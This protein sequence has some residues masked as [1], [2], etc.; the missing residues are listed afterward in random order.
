[1]KQGDFIEIDF[2]GRILLTGEIF[3]L[4]LES[5]AK[6][7]NIYNKNHKYKPKLVVV[8]NGMVI[9]GVERE[10]EKMKVG[11]E[12][13]FEVKP[14]DALGNR[15]QK[16]I[17]ILSL[18]KFKKENINPAPGIFVDI[19]GIT[20][21]IQS[22]SGGRVMVDFNHP[23]A[24]KALKYWIRINKIIEEPLEKAKAMLDHYGIKCET[25]LEGETLSIKLD[26]KTDNIVKEFL[27]NSITK[28]IREIK[29]MNFEEKS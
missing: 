14:E 24:G 8:G 1:M 7:S 13:E 20:A 25:K 4:T 2:V 26:K 9:P 11:E 12:K 18:A 22:V 17:K 19:D 16:L 10:L 29:D 15:S 5:V 21:K 23:L 27:K 6:E 28:W 3:D